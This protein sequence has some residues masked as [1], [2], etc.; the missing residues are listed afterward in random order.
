ME[1]KKIF[2]IDVRSI[3]VNCDFFLTASRKKH[4]GRQKKAGDGV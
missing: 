3:I 1:L 4:V 2:S